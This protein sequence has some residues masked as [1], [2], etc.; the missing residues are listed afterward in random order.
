MVAYT[1]LEPGAL[2][3]STSRSTRRTQSRVWES[4]PCSVYE[5]NLKRVMNPADAQS[6]VLNRNKA[7]GQYYVNLQRAESRIT[8]KE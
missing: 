5:R 6:T 8:K 7:E 2:Q 3:D 4:W 1:I